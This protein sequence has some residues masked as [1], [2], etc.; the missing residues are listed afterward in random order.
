MKLKSTPLLRLIL[1][2]VA[3][4]IPT[5][6]KAA[7]ILLDISSGSDPAAKAAD[8]TNAG[9]PSLVGTEAVGNLSVTPLNDTRTSFTFSTGQ[10][11]TLSARARGAYSVS[12]GNEMLN[13][14]IFLETTSGQGGPIRVSL[15][16]LGLAASTQYTLRLFS[17]NT[18]TNQLSAFTPLNSSTVSFKSLDPSN[19]TLIV[20]FTTSASYVNEPVEFTWARAAGSPTYAAFNGIAI[21]PAVQGTTLKWKCSTQTSIWTDKPDISLGEST[22]ASSSEASRI[23]IDSTHPLQRID[24]W[25]GCFNERGWKAMEV[26]TQTDRDTVM[27]A[28]FNKDTGLKL[29][30]C[31]TPIGASDY[32]IDLYSL[33]ETAGDTAMNNFSIDRDKQRLIPYIKSAQAIRPD[34]K[35]WAVPWSPPS[36]MKTNNSL[37][38][39][40][41]KDDDTTLDALALYF[42]KYVEAYQAEG[43]NIGMVMPQNEPNI[44]SNY[45]SCGWTGS[46]M[47]KFVGYHLGPKFASR[48]LTTKIYQG[49]FNESDRGGYSYWIEPSMTDPNVRQYVSGA[50]CQWSADVTMTETHFNRPELPLMQTETECGSTNT[51]DWSF[52]EYQFQLA[53]KW[54]TAGA[55]S[56]IIWNMVLDETGLSTGGWAQCSPIV[57]NSKSKQVTYTPFY[58]LYRHFSNYVKTGAHVLPIYS[59]SWGDKLA[60]VN[61]DGEVVV[62]VANT[63]ASSYAVT[64]S[65]DGSRSIPIMLPAHSFNTFTLPP[66]VASISALNQWRTQYFGTPENS[67]NAANDAD[68]DG[69]GMSNL[70]EFSTG[71]D[72]LH[73]EASVIQG[74][75]LNSTFEFNYQRS[76]AAMAMGIQFMVEWSD[77]LM[78]GSWST[79]GVTETVTSQNDLLQ[80]VTAIIPADSN[81]RFARLRITL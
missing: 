81:S 12:L 44:Q 45:T 9:V 34:L 27:N 53:K 41:I 77:N 79:A 37:V 60:F 2:L 67:G 76:K 11:M 46:Q 51:N 33:N 68:P 72:P 70:I 29:D 42:S 40:Y 15:G 43:I 64:L 36:W 50:G 8:F 62:V 71:G 1:L 49:T 69:D 23:L 56:N 47:A 35:F 22:V 54:F 21:S 10:T 65:I 16:N 18:S 52:A 30:Y 66:P 3:T 78:D 17:S 59:S 25:G 39:G 55:G 74:H 38:G 4:D 14:Y 7:P 24:G 48:G 58:H 63:S 28:L 19:G 61:P 75:K 26:L 31:R 80:Q 57:V 6:C 13:D 5:L 32:A 73:S 20:N